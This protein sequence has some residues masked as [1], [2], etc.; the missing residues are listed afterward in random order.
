MGA[1]KQC[2]GR[3]LQTAERLYK[4]AVVHFH[5]HLYTIFHLYSVTLGVAGWLMMKIDDIRIIERVSV[6]LFCVQ[7]RTVTGNDT[8]V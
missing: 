5:F 2:C 6:Y 8:L 3:Q 4:F 1:M 7:Q